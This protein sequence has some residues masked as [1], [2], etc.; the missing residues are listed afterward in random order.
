M[1]Q[2]QLAG[3][4]ALVT[5]AGSGMGA[6][7]ATALA[8]E[9]ARV[10]AVDLNASAANRMAEEIASAGGAAFAVQADVRLTGDVQRAVATTLERCGTIDVL[11]CIAGVVGRSSVEQ[12][13]EEEWDR[14]L[15]VNL[16]GV[17]LCCQAVLPIM[18][19]KRGGK[20]VIL[21]SMAGRATS[22]FGG[23]HYTASKAGVL[24]FCRHLAREAAP[25]GINVNAINPGIIDTPMVRLRTTPEELAKVVSG[26]PFRRMG[27][28]EDVAD[29]VVFLAS[30]QAAYI[31]GASVDIHG[32]EMFI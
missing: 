11:A 4:V 15:D 29:L 12:I 2:D 1:V 23:A 20:I 17:F 7:T 19:A 3:K 24:G 22:T 16:K 18:K 6:A 26:I 13:T 14:V 25:Y 30:D 9:G 5:G 28:A 32:G 21:G 27:T 31:T 8:R 10:A